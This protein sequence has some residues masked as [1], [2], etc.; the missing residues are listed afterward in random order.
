MVAGGLAGRVEAVG[1]VV[2]GLGEGGVPRA[3]AAL[4]L[5]GGY[6]VEAEGVALGLE[7]RA[8]VGTRG[9]RQR[10]GVKVPSAMVRT[11][12]PGPWMLRPT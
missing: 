4:D 12:A 2:V 11:M 7:H 10:E 3:Q 8:P 9:L 1:L 6:M 5:V